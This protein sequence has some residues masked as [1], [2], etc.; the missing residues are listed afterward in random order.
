MVQGGELVKI[1]S[2]TRRLVNELE[3][4]YVE[5]VGHVWN[6]SGWEEDPRA[7]ERVVAGFKAVEKRDVGGKIVVS[8]PEMGRSHHDEAV[9]VM[10][11]L[12]A[13]GAGE[14]Q[15]T[16]TYDSGMHRYGTSVTVLETRLR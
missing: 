3:A 16:H 12:R 11:A 10:R 9:A 2:P 1:Y 7:G 4:L 5:P 8:I 13:A 14:A 15:K 6:G